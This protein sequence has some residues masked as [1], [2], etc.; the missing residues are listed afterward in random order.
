MP[1]LARTGGGM[2]AGS[3]GMGGGAIMGDMPLVYDVENT[4]ADCPVAASFPAFSALTAIANF[5]DPFLKESGG[6]IPSR[7]DWRCRRAE[8]SAQIQHWE[9]G[10]NPPPTASEV[11]ATFASNK[12]TVNV[13]VGS[14]SIALTTTITLPTGGTGPYPA[15]IRM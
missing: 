3:G 6:Q 4:G 1:S 11:T 13:K 2:L 14:K 8:I 10:T 12:L 5:P 7:A 15:V 9:L